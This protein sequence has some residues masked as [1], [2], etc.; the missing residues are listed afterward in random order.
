[1]GSGI[2]LTK[3]EIKDIIKV[4][5]SLENRGILLRGTTRKISRQE[6]GFFNCLRPLTTAG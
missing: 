1:M 6:G 4:Y 2:I 3:N 5:K